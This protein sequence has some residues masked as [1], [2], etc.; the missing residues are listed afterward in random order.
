MT[1]LNSTVSSQVR[2]FANDCLLYHPIKMSSTSGEAAET[3]RHCGTGKIDG[4]CASIPRNDRSWGCSGQIKKTCNFSTPLYIKG[5]P[6]ANVSSTPYLGVC[7]SETLEWEAHINKITSKANYSLGMKACPP[8]L[9][10]PSYFSLVRSSLEHSSFVWNPS[11]QKGIDKLDKKI[12]ISSKICHP[13][14]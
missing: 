3:Y 12:M 2:L 9:R 5:E 1:S 6:L 13:K 14:L 4:G 8:K 11:I 10:N 7:L